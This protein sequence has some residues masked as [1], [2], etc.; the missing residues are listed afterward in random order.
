M[1][2]LLLFLSL[3]FCMHTFSYASFPVSETE[4]PKNDTELNFF[5]SINSSISATAAAYGGGKGMSV[6]A[7]VCGIV[8]LFF[9]GLILGPLAIVFGAIG[10]KRDGRGMA[11]AG[12]VCGIV[13][14]LLS[15]LIIAAFVAI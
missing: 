2:K 1:K 4:N 8:G 7:L 12:L 11:I 10:M 6:A 15:L 13:A 5:E 3:I 9:G 14:T